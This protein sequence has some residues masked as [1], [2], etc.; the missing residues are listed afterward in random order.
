[1]PGDVWSQSD[2]LARQGTQYRPRAGILGCVMTPPCPS[3]P[4]LRP[5]GWGPFQALT[6]LYTDLGSCPSLTGTMCIYWIIH[7]PP[8]SEG[9]GSWAVS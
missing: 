3:G 9:Q 6:G 4:W 2:G 8:M 1:M 7:I 5:F